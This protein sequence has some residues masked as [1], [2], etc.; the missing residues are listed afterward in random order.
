M[1]SQGL[2]TPRWRGSAL[3]LIFRVSKYK[4]TMVETPQQAHTDSTISK[5]PIDFPLA[6]FGYR[7]DAEHHH[8][9]TR[10]STEQ[11]SSSV[12]L[13]KSGYRLNKG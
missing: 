5:I 9:Y 12:W 2:N 10:T 4:L 3:R 7:L 1:P 11:I 13:Q 8:K 6:K